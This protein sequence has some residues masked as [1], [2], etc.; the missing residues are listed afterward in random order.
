MI[1]SGNSWITLYCTILAIHG[2]DSDASMVHPTICIVR[3]QNCVDPYDLYD[4]DYHKYWG[5]YWRSLNNKKISPIILPHWL[6]LLYLVSPLKWILYSRLIK[7]F[8]DHCHWLLAFSFT[9]R[10]K[11]WWFLVFQF[12]SSSVL[13]LNCCWMVS[14]NSSHVSN[15]SCWFSY[16]TTNLMQVHVG[17]GAHIMRS[18]LLQNHRRTS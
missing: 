5:L 10:I 11:N 8:I 17:I 4:F 6:L 14:K 1:P 13:A 18:L 9:R 2:C 12:K 3:S 16:G 7:I 15:N